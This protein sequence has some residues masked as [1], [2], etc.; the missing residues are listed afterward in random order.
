MTDAVLFTKKYQY[1]PAGIPIISTSM[2]SA[3]SL[4]RI[5]KFAKKS[6]CIIYKRENMQSLLNRYISTFSTEYTTTPAVVSHDDALLIIEKWAQRDF[7]TIEKV[8]KDYIP[9]LFIYET[10]EDKV[11]FPISEVRKFIIDTSKKPYE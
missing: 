1:I 9:G 3:K 6:E 11:E 10:P 2:R 5:E 4:A 7:G 8:K